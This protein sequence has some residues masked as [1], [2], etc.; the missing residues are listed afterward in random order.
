MAGD[1]LVSLASCLVIGVG[2][3][4]LNF[5]CMAGHT[6]VVRLFLGFEAVSTAACVAG[7][8]VKLARLKAWTHEPRGVSIIFSKIPAVGVKVG[9]FK[10]DQVIVVKEFF[11]RRECC[12]Q[13]DHL[14]MASSTRSIALVW[15]K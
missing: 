2:R 3:G 13:R 10:C 4:I 12:C 7:D 1:A 5:F 15:S 6:G 8:T 11:A 9:V 14:S